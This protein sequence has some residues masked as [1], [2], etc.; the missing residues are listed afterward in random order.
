VG[1]AFLALGIFSS[2]ITDNQIIA[3]VIAFG[4]LLLFWLLGWVEEIGGTRWQGV[5][6]HLSMLGHFDSFARGVLDTRNFLYYFSFIFFFLF[7]TKRQLESR[8][9][10]G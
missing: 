5:F 3:A 6:K 10:R 2:S 9:W 4:L 7:L 1:G 8:R